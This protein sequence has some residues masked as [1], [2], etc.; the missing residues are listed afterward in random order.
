MAY[1]VC[2]GTGV[3]ARTELTDVS[4]RSDGP[5]RRRRRRL[6]TGFTRMARQRIRSIRSATLSLTAC[7]CFYYIYYIYY[8][9]TYLKSTMYVYNT[10]NVYI[11]I[12]TEKPMG[13]P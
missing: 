8:L 5:V 2:R 11:P 3:C 10:L 4:R 12:P 7:Q 13:I 9:P 1:V 6:S